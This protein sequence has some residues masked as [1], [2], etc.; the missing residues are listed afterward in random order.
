M[1]A[2]HKHSMRGAAGLLLLA[3]CGCSGSPEK[4][5]TGDIKT[6]KG[7]ISVPGVAFVDGRD[8]Q[9][10]PPLTMMNVNVWDGP[11]R[12]RRI[13]EAA[14]GGQVEVLAAR[15]HESEGRHYF[16]ITAGGCEGWLPESF[17]S[18]ESQPVAGEPIR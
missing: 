10:T 18:P 12:Q 14:H 1:M 13:C 5:L 8:T 9:A 4:A 7:M 2:P 15:L 16:H 11:E 17:L 6:S 3:V